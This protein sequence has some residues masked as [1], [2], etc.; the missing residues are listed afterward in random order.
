[1][2]LHE[3]VFENDDEEKVTGM[4]AYRVHYDKIGEKY[5]E[6]TQTHPDIFAS[7]VSKAQYEQMVRKILAERPWL[8]I[9]D[10]LGDALGLS[11]AVTHQKQ[12][13]KEKK[14]PE[15]A[16][17]QQAPQPKPAQSRRQQ[18]QQARANN[19]SSSSTSKSAKRSTQKKPLTPTQKKMMQLKRTIKQHTVDPY[20]RAEKWTKDMLK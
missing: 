19:D 11:I 1:M 13:E 7:Q 3:L 14:K 20:K 2:R 10:A 12:K 16:K 5:L 18:R 17:K 4:D 9:E 8:S 15:Q 6:L